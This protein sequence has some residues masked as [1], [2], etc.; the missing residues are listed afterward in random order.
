MTAAAVTAASDGSMPGGVT[1]A[2]IPA[3]AASAAFAATLL[4]HVAPAGMMVGVATCVEVLECVHMFR[5]SISTMMPQ[6]I[7]KLRDECSES[8]NR[9]CG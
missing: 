4:H 1:S 5:D 8:S 6:R 9:G 3:A 7:V 2:G